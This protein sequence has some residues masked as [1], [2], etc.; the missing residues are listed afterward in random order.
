MDIVGFKHQFSHSFGDNSGC[1]L[2]ET[3]R[4]D[5]LNPGVKYE[6]IRR[7]NFFSTYVLGPVLVLNPPF[8]KYI[9]GLMGVSE[10]HLEFE[11]ECFDAYITRVKEFS[12]PSRGF[13]Y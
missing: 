11:E 13:L 1:Y 8:T 12:E 9:L 5:G 10:P 4:G 2:F 3:T 6:G 7:R